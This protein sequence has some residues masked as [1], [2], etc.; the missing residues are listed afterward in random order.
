M[1]CADSFSHFQ[2]VSKFPQPQDDVAGMFRH[3]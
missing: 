3:V 1:T 2:L